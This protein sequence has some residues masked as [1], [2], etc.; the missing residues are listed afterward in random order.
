MSQLLYGVIG[1]KI[2]PRRT[3]LKKV[4]E[5]IRRSSDDSAFKVNTQVSIAGTLVG[6]YGL[7]NTTAMVTLALCS[8]LNLRAW[9]TSVGPALVF[10]VVSETH[11]ALP[12]A[13]DLSREIGLVER[14]AECRILPL[15]VKL[16]AQES[17]PKTR[18]CVRDGF[19]WRQEPV[20]SSTRK[21]QKSGALLGCASAIWNSLITNRFASGR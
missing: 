7:P 12:E 8:R 9:P 19:C 13:S 6:D 16:R 4:C 18:Q 1:R 11:A 20:H 21:V 17:R 10:P 5:W 3:L 14:V 2:F 15:H